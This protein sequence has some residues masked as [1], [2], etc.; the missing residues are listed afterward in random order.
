M[1]TYGDGVAD[2]DVNALIDFH[3]QRGKTVTITAIQPGSRF[4]T[5]A[6]DD[7]QLISQFKEKSKEEGGWINGGFMVLEP[8]IMDYL[9]DD[10]TVLEKYPLETLATEGE[11]VAYQHHGFWQCMDTLRD[12]ELLESLLKSG[13]APWKV[14]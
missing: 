10:T 14:W 3:K 11:L 8:R 5:L 13:N 9:Q 6:L 2:V 1:L 7:N 4:G 12:K